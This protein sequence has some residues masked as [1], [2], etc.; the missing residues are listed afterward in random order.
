VKERMLETWKTRN[1]YRKI[2]LFPEVC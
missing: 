2:L 1:P